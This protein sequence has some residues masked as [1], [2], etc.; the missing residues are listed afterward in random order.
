MRQSLLQLIDRYQSGT[1]IKH[2][3]TDAG[4]RD[5]ARKFAWQQAD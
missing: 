3:S 1:G 5:C 4:H 2:F